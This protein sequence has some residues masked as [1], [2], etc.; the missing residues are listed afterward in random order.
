MKKQ[1]YDIT[2]VMC[3][4][5][6]KM[7]DEFMNARNEEGEFLKAVYFHGGFLMMGCGGKTAAFIC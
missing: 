5:F 1:V 4:I 7:V 6:D 2:P 3:D